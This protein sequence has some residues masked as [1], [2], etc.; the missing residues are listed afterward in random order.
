MIPELAMDAR[1]RLRAPVALN[2]VKT[3]AVQ[4]VDLPDLSPRFRVREKRVR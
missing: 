1:L 2:D 3:L 4:E